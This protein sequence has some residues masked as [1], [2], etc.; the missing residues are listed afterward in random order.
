MMN[1]IKPRYWLTKEAQRDA[2]RRYKHRQYAKWLL[3]I[4]FVVVALWLF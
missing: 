3:P 1:H 2:E 4:A